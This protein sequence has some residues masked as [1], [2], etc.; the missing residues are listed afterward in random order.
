MFEVRRAE[1]KTSAGRR[2]VL[3]R[4]RRTCLRTVLMDATSSAPRA[5]LELAARIFDERANRSRA[6]SPPRAHGPRRLFRTILLV[7]LA[8]ANLELESPLGKAR[9]RR[10]AAC[11]DIYSAC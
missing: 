5:T 4:T 8:G 3:T 10:T 7:E 6:G 11:L 1:E 2:G 9:E